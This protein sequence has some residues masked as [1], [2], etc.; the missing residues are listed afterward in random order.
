MQK[1]R[2]IL[3]ALALVFVAGCNS[4]PKSPERIAHTVTASV[5][6]TADAA[7]KAWADYVVRERIRVDG[8]FTS[9][10]VNAP[11]AAASLAND[12][13]MVSAAYRRYQDVTAAAITGASSLS[14]PTA[15]VTEQIQAA[16]NL[17]VST[18][19]TAIQ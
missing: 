9:N 10:D 12:E 4:A 5:I 6:D 16:V 1:I 7:I 8:L 17:L 18:I 15:S 3:A 14:N 13:A 19:S 2:I 11:Q